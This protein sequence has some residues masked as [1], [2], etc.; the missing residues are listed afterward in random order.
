MRRLQSLRRREKMFSVSGI[1]LACS[2]HGGE[3]MQRIESKFIELTG[4][5]LMKMLGPN[6]EA[7]A[8]RAAG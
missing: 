4:G 6:E 5:A 1:V 8:L 3:I 7:E 2:L